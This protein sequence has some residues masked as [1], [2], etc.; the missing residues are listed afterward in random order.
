MRERE[1]SVCVCVRE[2]ERSV[3]VCVWCRFEE[4]LAAKWPSEKRFG[5]EGCEV[6]IPAMK[7]IIDN[8]TV[9]GVESYVIGMP[10]RLITLYVIIFTTSGFK[11]YI[12]TY[13]NV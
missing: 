12:H 10:H 13:E 9:R 11:G 5:L 3:C 2:R 7:E 8:S 6:M 4:Y 1:R